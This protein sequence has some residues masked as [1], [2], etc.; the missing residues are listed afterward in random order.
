MPLPPERHTQA[1]GVDSRAIVASRCGSSQA[2]KPP[3]ATFGAPF[4][5]YTRATDSA[6]VEN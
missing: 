6:P 1:L 4:S 2:H 5:K 3:R